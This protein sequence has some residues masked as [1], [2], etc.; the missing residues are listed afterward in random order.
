[1]NQGIIQLA[2]YLRDVQEVTV[3]DQ[4]VIETAAP[5]WSKQRAMNDVM[6]MQVCSY[7]N[8]FGINWDKLK[9]LGDARN[10]CVRSRHGENK[11][12]FFWRSSYLCE[13]SLLILIHFKFTSPFSLWKLTLRLI[14][15][16]KP[17]KP[18][19]SVSENA[20]LA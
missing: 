7:H 14:Y 19:L 18:I 12:Y 9:N 13:N 11:D 1:M 16:K 4:S 2:L 5:F 10:S 6:I 17:I 8:Y 15:T 20:N 3:K